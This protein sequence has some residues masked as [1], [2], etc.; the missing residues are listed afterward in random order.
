MKKIKYVQ[1]EPAAVLLDSSIH[2]LTAKQF[3]CYWKIIMH[4]YCN[5]GKMKFDKNN[6]KKL[7]NCKTGFEK[8]WEKIEKNFQIKN[9]VLRHSRVSKELREA[10]RRV[11]VAQQSGLRGARKRWAGHSNP[12]GDPIASTIAKESKGK[13]SEV[14]E[15]KEKENNGKVNEEKQ[16]K[17]HSINFQE[18]QKKTI[19]GSG[20]KRHSSSSSVSSLSSCLS[21][22]TS[23]LEPLEGTLANKVLKFN[24]SLCSIIVPR[25]NS[26]ITAFRNIGNWLKMQIL[27]GKFTEDIFGR[28]LDYAQ[29][30]AGDTSRKPAAVFTAILKDQLNYKP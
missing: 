4:L 2:Q 20:L 22:I 1:L 12:N 10:K 23:R 26:D 7:C 19:N 14:K 25:S 17:F 16:N 15:N 9:D 21:S 3:G 13:K 28:V 24:E 18:P 5:G 30:A 11:Q 6:L 27:T 29:Q 8:I